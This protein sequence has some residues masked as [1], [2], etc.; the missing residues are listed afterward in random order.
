MLS[1][2]L[3]HARACAL[4]RTLALT[5]LLIPV[6]LIPLLLPASPAGACSITA[7]GRCA[8]DPCPEGESCKKASDGLSCSCVK[9]DSRA[10]GC[11]AAP[12][13]SASPG[14]VTPALQQYRACAA[15]CKANSPGVAECFDGCA[16][17]YGAVL[18]GCPAAGSP[19][20]RNACGDCLANCS[21]DR[22]ECFL[23]CRQQEPW[24]PG[25]YDDCEDIDCS[26]SCKEV[27]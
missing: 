15:S 9:D 13:R 3:V 4:R 10:S 5:A 11:D 21:E 2:I 16:E 1:K 17:V 22:Y 26:E 19:P 20:V 27:C 7:S 23:S 8:G 12:R 24:D 25:C 14:C 18:A 6:L